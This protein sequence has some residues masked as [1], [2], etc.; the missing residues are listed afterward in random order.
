MD[1]RKTLW[2]SKPQNKTQKSPNQHATKAKSKVTIETSAVNSNEGKTKPEL[3][4]TVLTITT[5]LVVVKGTLTLTTKFPTKPTQ[6]IRIIKKSEA[7]DHFTHAVRPVVKVTIPQKS[8]ALEQTQLIERLLSD[9]RKDKTRS[10]REMLK[11]IQ[12][13]MFELQP[14]L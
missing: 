3:T 7:L 6:T 4:R 2:R 1:C 11:A 12:M 13:G 8:V 14:K 10:N 9:D 5:I